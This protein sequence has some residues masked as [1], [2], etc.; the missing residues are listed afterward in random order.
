MIFNNSNLDKSF[1]DTS[2][3]RR[4]RPARG[5]GYY[6][7]EQRCRQKDFRQERVRSVRPTHSAR[8]LR[9]KQNQTTRNQTGRTK[10]NRAKWLRATQTKRFP[11]KPLNGRTGSA[12][13]AGCGTGGSVRFQ[14][15]GYCRRGLRLFAAG[16]AAMNFAETDSADR[17]H[18]ARRTRPHGTM[19]PRGSDS[20]PVRPETDVR[21]ACGTPESG[22]RSQRFRTADS[23]HPN[24]SHARLKSGYFWWIRLAT[25]GLMPLLPRL[26]W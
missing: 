2:C 8:R 15:D 7:G 14:P 12:R 21:A 6:C 23:P 10:Q 20:R 3:R 4:R 19:P 1:I 24:I 26:I 22:R 9:V 11:A 25:L 18:K 5:R 17:P 16:A 13:V